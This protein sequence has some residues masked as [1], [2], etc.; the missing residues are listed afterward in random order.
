MTHR[1]IQIGRQQRRERIERHAGASSAL[2][3][4]NVLTSPQLLELTEAHLVRSL[5]YVY[6]RDRTLSN[7]A[8]AF[9]ALLNPVAP[10]L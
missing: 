10:N 1:N 8:R 6:H 3:F 2:E 7:A 4:F 5:G 9:I